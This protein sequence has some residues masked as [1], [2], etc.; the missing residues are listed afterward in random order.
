MRATRKVLC[1]KE[2][3]VL[4][5]VTAHGSCSSGDVGSLRGVYG[6]PG[7]DRLC[8]CVWSHLP[9]HMRLFALDVCIYSHMHADVHAFACFAAASKGLTNVHL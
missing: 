6:E 3:I 1:Y 9:V 8:D 5:R 2:S 4:Q 7:R